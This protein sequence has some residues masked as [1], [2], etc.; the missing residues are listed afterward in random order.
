MVTVDTRFKI[1]FHKMK[2]CN[3]KFVFYSFNFSRIFVK[4]WANQKHEFEEQKITGGCP[5]EVDHENLQ[6][7]EAKQYG[8]LIFIWSVHI[9]SMFAISLY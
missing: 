1:I 7:L 5:K 9:L 4:F 3:L 2:V 8:S 6:K